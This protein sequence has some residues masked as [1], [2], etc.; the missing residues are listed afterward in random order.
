MTN[1]ATKQ[2]DHRVGR[3]GARGGKMSQ[4]PQ[5]LQRGDHVCLDCFLRDAFILTYHSPT[6][7]DFLEILLS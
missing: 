6:F 1:S 7:K 4:E 3:P 5:N 2:R